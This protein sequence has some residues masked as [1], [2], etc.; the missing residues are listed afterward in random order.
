[1]GLMRI[2]VVV[3]VLLVVSSSARADMFVSPGVSIAYGT[4]GWA[5]GVEVSAGIPVAQLPLSSGLVAG[6][7]VAPFAAKGQ[8]WGRAYAEV[9][10]VTLFAG[11]GVG[12]TIMLSD[13][14]EI[15]WQITPFLAL[16]V[17]LV[18]DKTSEPY[19]FVVPYYRYTSS[20]EH[21]GF[22]DVGMF[23]KAVWVPNGR[24][25]KCCGH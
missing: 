9:E 20:S 3:V 8:P 7:E 24:R 21:A 5:F 11:I 6:F 14:S 17:Q 4:R 18:S 23:G 10:L 22:H 15:A 12:P 16:P 19:P 13:D 2:L 25:D 1:V